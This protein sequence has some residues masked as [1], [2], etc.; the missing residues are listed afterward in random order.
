MVVDVP[1]EV[2]VADVN[3]GEDMVDVV[4]VAWSSPWASV[5]LGRCDVRGASAL[6]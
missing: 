2:D 1:A 6:G 5:R 3:G 4:L